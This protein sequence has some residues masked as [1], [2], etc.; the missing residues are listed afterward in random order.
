MEFV[1]R[2]E[3]TDD[4]EVSCT[5]KRQRQGYEKNHEVHLVRDLIANIG[6]K[7][8]TKEISIGEQFV[9]EKDQH[10]NTT[11]HVAGN[12]DDWHRHLDAVEGH[13][14]FE[15]C[16]NG[17]MPLQSDYS[18]CDGGH[19]YKDILKWSEDIVQHVTK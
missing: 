13:L 1:F 18:L 6:K 4:V 9:L 2:P 11:R 16:Y 5:L 7:W 15:R 19:D 3:R 17:S 10:R 12:P 14:R 8:K